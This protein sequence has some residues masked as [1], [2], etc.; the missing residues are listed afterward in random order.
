MA[1]DFYGIPGGSTAA[2]MKNCCRFGG[3]FRE[4]SKGDERGEGGG[5]IAA[6]R[7]RIKRAVMGIEGGI[8]RGGNGLRRE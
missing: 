1:V 7:R 8:N 2:P 4:R 5:F 3:D 6:A